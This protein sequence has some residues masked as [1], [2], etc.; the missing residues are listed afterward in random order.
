MFS[1][2]EKSLFFMDILIKL[3]SQ[4]STIN[5]ENLYENLCCLCLKSSSCFPCY[6][7]KEKSRWFLRKNCCL[8]KFMIK[9]FIY[10]EELFF[11]VFS[12]TLYFMKWKWKLIWKFWC[13]NYNFSPHRLT[14]LSLFHVV[15]DLRLTWVK[16]KLNNFFNH[17][18]NLNLKR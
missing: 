15:K 5:Y 11:R 9:F 7:K 18:L 12:T 1:Q 13:L 3:T 2:K 8:E 10:L 14:P 4:L 16:R 6:N 17:F